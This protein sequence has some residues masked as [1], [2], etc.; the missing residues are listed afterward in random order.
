MKNNSAATRQRAHMREH[1][2]L[3]RHATA[4]M[5]HRRLAE[6]SP[7]AC[8]VPN[9]DVQGTPPHRGGSSSTE[10]ITDGRGGRGQQ[11]ESLCPCDVST[12]PAVAPGPPLPRP[13]LFHAFAVP[14][15]SASLTPSL[16]GLPRWCLWPTGG[17]VPPPPPVTQPSTAAAVGP[18]LYGGVPCSSAC[19]HMQAFGL[20]DA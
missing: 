2:T 8:M 17:V 14:L 6:H 15:V 3:N 5:Q 1:E 12:S 13:Y 10:G 7:K 19:C 11:R 16:S 18:S 9:R 20:C 4:F